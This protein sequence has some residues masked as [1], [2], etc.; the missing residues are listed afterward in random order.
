VVEGGFHAFDVMCAKAPITGRFAS[1][2]IQALRAA[3]T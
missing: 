1:S 3:L 2:Q